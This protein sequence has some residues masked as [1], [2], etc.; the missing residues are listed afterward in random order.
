MANPMSIT[1]QEVCKRYSKCVNCP[2]VY[3]SCNCEEL[4]QNEINDI[5]YIVE[6]VEQRTQTHFH[7]FGM[8]KEIMARLIAKLIWNNE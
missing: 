3:G 1:R 4:K 8:S 5:M 6:V 7:K 2:L